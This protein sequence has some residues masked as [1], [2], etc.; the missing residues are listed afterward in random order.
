MNNKKII[1]EETFEIV[2]NQKL[3]NKSLMASALGISRPTLDKI[4]AEN[5]KFKEIIDNASEH[6][7]DFAESQLH[8][9]MKGI[10]IKDDNGKLIGWE[11]KPDKTSIIFYLKTKGKKRGYV[12]THQIENV[13]KP[14][15]DVGDDTLK[16]VGQVLKL[17]SGADR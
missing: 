3:G 11:E 7:I 4:I 13:T 15:L 5:G 14:E 17:V 1:N 16:N 9:L 8:L 12:E 10:P 6:A 2:A